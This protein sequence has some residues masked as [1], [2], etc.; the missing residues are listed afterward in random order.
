MRL[1]FSRANLLPKSR[2]EGLRRY[3]FIGDS[4]TFGTGVT[5]DETLPACAERQMNHACAD[6]PVEAVNLGVSGYN[7][8][9]SWMGF[10]ELPQVYDGVVLTLCTNDS[11]FFCRTYRVPPPELRW[12]TWEK[13]H[14]GGNGIARGFEDMALFSKQTGLRVAVCFSYLADFHGTR[15][16]RDI[17]AEQCALHGFVFIDSW[18]A[19]KERG[20][21]NEALM[22]SECDS[23][24]SALVHEAVGRYLVRRLEEERWFAP[25]AETSL[26]TIAERIVVSARAM[27]AADNYPPDVAQ[28]WAIRVLDIKLHRARRLQAFSEEADDFAAVSEVRA[29]LAA[30][31]LAWHMGQ[32]IQAFFHELSGLSQALTLR[33][34]VSEEERLKLDELAFALQTE[35]W[36]GLSEKLKEIPLNLRGPREAEAPQA[37]EVIDQYLACLEHARNAFAAMRAEAES[38]LQVPGRDPGLSN[39]DALLLL[40]DRTDLECR[41]LKQSSAGF[42]SAA[43]RAAPNLGKE[44]RELVSNLGNAAIVAAQ[45]ALAFILAWPA[46]AR[47]MGSPDYADFTTVEIHVRGPVIASKSPS[48]VRVRAEYLAPYRLPSENNGSFISDG[49]VKFVKLHLPLFYT[50]RIYILAKA[51]GGTPI[52]FDLVKVEVYNLARQRRRIPPG[53]FFTPSTD[54]R[55]SPILYL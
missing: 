11:E 26:G 23:H 42:V 49:S 7:L 29:N 9:N 39:L 35:N 21:S 36:P 17:I 34:I 1:I 31:H 43:D 48:F 14:V 32:R 19:I 41:L 27:I 28:R 52:D 46:K 18:I 54:W 47:E 20:F 16:V 53:Q 13:S 25:R 45:K 5:P 2:I 3:A 4:I 33:L 12:P 50:G 55:V 15:R 38:Q 10:K 6:S 44:D 24:P 40:V 51:N 8:W 22:I 37:A 30:S